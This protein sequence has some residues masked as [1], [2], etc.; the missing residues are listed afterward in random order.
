MRNRCLFAAF[1]FAGVLS[2]AQKA[3]R[4]SDGKPDLQGV[5]ANNNATPM[6]RP[7]EL[8]GRT[9]LTDEEVAAMKK[10]AA[11]LYNGGGDAAFG[12][13]IFNTVYA[14]VKGIREETGP[15]KKAANEFD[16]DTGDY[17]S[18]W[19]VAREWDN[20][21]S[22]VTDPPDGRIPALTP[23]GQARRAANFAAMRRPAEG[24][25]DRG[26][27]ERCLT[28]GSP[29]LT[30]GYQSYM[31]IQQ[32]ADAVIL[33]TEMIHDTRVIALDGRPHI[34]SNITKWMG[35]SRGHWEGD[36]LVVDTTN[37]RPRAFMSI[38][39]E[40]LHVIER[41]TRTGPQ[42]LKYEITIND[43][44]TWTKPWSLMISLKASDHPIYEYACHEGN[45]GLAG[46]LA[47]ARA[48]ERAAASSGGTSK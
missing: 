3:P 23:E 18:E 41:F 44:A 1:C 42:T 27:Q 31:Q 26:L 20:R 29:Q 34:P 11:E 33:L 30:A 48:E 4:T 47:G 38:S 24:P 17:S 7:K 16:G 39:S 14:A 22:L 2:F 37:Y 32:T 12:D 15:H 46:I 45:T 28:Y 35:D 8:A 43:P 25:E 9:S 19:I 21:T 36:T 40:K 5:W 6:E 10:K 13:T